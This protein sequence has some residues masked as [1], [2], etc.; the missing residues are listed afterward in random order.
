[1]RDWRPFHGPAFPSNMQSNPFEL[2]FRES[3]DSPLEL[4]VALP[5]EAAGVLLAPSVQCH[6]PTYTRRQEIPGR[7]QWFGA[8]T[9]EMGRWR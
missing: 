8:R 4:D 3:T 9:L 5:L 1:M 2:Q 6:S 7:I